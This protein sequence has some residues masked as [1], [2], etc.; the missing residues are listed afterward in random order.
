[1]KTVAKET[2]TQIALRKPSE[3]AREKPGCVRVF[4][5]K[6]KKKKSIVIYQK[7]VA[8]CTTRHFK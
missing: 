4:A 8:N 3:E 5:G 6:E 7:I 2:A 1:M